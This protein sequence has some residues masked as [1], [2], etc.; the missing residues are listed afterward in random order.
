[1][2]VLNKISDVREAQKAVRSRG[3]RTGLV[4]TMGALHDGHLSLIQA[5]K[6]EC[7]YTVVSIF[8]NPT[9]FGPGEDFDR[10]PRPIESDLEKCRREGV[11]VVFNP[12]PEEMYPADPVTTVQVAKLT[13]KLCG[14]FRPGHFAGVATVVTKLFN[15][16]QPD[17]AFFGQKDAQ[18]ALVIRRMIQDLNIPVALRVCP[19]VRSE[20]GLA[21]SSR[22]HYLGEGELAQA[23]CLYQALQEAR[24]L[25]KKGVR[26]SAEILSALR[27]RIEQAGPCRIQYLSIVD[28]DT[29]Q[30]VDT[31]DRPVLIALAVKIGQTRLIDNII[32][33]ADGNDATIT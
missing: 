14:E 17:A 15:I 6:R 1:M 22:N 20:S 33:D 19:T 9:Q 26:D 4:P 32:V 5:A 29:L 24:T 18:Q 30:E 31:V 10:Y 12:P 28:P 25:L 27:R 3:Q 8:V 2:L 16:V 7:G 21:L 13:D 23:A 11:D